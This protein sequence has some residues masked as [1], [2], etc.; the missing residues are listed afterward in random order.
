MALTISAQSWQNPSMLAFSALTKAVQSL[1]QALAIAATRPDDLL[2]RDGCIQRFEYTYKLSVKF[3]RRQLEA[4][5]DS[6]SAIDEL[7][8]KDMVRA[9]AER[10]LIDDPQTWFSYRELK[11]ITAH[12]YDAD[13]ALTVFTELHAFLSSAERL[14]KKLT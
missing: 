13:K 3:M 12:T 11:N 6:P 1:S 4:F 5:A 8:F 9:A 14:F 7:G 2:L 10:G